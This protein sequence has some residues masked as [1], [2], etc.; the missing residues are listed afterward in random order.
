MKKFTAFLCT[1]ALFICSGCSLMQSQSSSS[2]SGFLGTNS[3]SS[4]SSS[5]NSTATPHTHADTDGNE[6]C[7]TCNA[8]LPHVHKD[9]DNNEIC[10]KCQASLHAHVNVN[11]Y[12][13]TCG[14]LLHTH[15][16]VDGYCSVCN[17]T[18][19][20]HADTNADGK[21]DVCKTV[22]QTT[23]CFYSINDLHGKFDDTD[24]NMGVDEMTT[25]LRNA[26]TVNENTVLLSA[27]D[28]WQGSTESNATKGNI[29]TE[30][31]NDLGFAAMALGNHEYDWGENAIK[32]NA[33]LANFPLLAINV[34]DKSTGERAE[35]CDASVMIDMSGVKIGVI[36]AIGDCYGDIAAEQVQGVTFKTKSALTALVKTESMRLREQGADM[37]VYLL[38]DGS[39]SSSTYDTALSNGYVDIVFE[40]HTH[41]TVQYQDTYGVWHLQAGGDN[42]K[43]LSSATFT[44]NLLND[45]VNA[46]SAKVVSSSTYAS[47]A[48]DPIVDQLLQKYDAVLA[49]MKQALGTNASYRDYDDLSNYAAK[50]YFAVGMSRW[51]SNPT[52]K[53]KIVLGGGY[54]GVRSPYKLYA[55]QVT[56]AD[57][58]PL[59]PFDNALV[60]CKVS[61]ARLKAQ[62][63]NATNSKYYMYYGVDGTAIKNNIVDSETYYVVVDTYCANYNFYG[64]GYMEIVEY[65]SADKTY[66]G[67]DAIAD[68]TRGGGLSANP[69]SPET[70][71][72]Q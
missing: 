49:P 36:G 15:V 64:Y 9:A 41:Q 34:Y 25:Y 46:Q 10:D 55:G 45:T 33:Q 30:W 65:Y 2:F 35:Y 51:G 54:I 48:D 62:F 47:L 27:G 59:F 19:H 5:S 37:I 11:G 68:Y 56:Y 21:C 4:S 69:P 1:I 60:L 24:S 52:Y 57:L 3:S 66:Y 29:V 20:D 31:M 44:V 18:M 70:F 63:I 16:A 71:K 42:Q 32:A 6:I 58:Y 40:G 38:H 13:S 17:A 67:R 23:V 14:T 53:G 50:S 28:M 26:K 61:G 7:D 39:E 22:V 12:C 72:V 8:Q 43:G